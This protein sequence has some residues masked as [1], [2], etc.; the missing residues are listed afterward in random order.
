[1]NHRKV[2]LAYALSSEPRLNWLALGI[3]LAA[4]NFCDNDSVHEAAAKPA[5]LAHHEWVTVRT[6]REHHG[7]G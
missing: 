6:V 4:W 5:A 3:L 1:M 7:R 2:P